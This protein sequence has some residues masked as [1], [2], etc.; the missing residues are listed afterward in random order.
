MPSHLA[1]IWKRSPNKLRQSE[2]WL[3]YFCFIGLFGAALLLFLINLGGSPLVDGN[4]AVLARVA[5]EIYQHATEIAEWLFPTLLNEPYLDR[6]PLIHV[7]VAG[8]YAIAGVNEFTTRLPGAV[9]AAISVLLLYQVGREIFIVRL[10][11]LFSALIYLTCLPV[12]RMGRLAM[13]DGPLLCFGILT[14]WAVLRSRRDLRWALVVGIGLG[15]V[16]LTHGFFCLPLGAIAI[17]FLAWDTPRLLGS[18]YLWSGISLGLAPLF[19]WYTA[20]WYHHPELHDFATTIALL[21]SR[22]TPTSWQELPSWRN[23]LLLLLQYFVPW[24]LMFYGGLKLARENLH[25]GWAKLIVVWSGIYAIAMLISLTSQSWYFLM[26]YPALALAGGAQLD[27]IYNLPSYIPYPRYWSIG[28]AIMSVFTA[29]VG[30]YCGFTSSIDFSL[31]L[32]FAFLTLTFGATAIFIA[33]R[34]RQFISLLFWG[35][36]VS[37]LLLVASSH[38]VWELD[39]LEPV[40]PIA[41]IINSNVPQQEIIYTSWSQYPSSLNFYSDRPIITEAIT[42]LKQRWQ[43]HHSVYLLVDRSTIEKLNISPKAIVKPFNDPASNWML[44]IK[45]SG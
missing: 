33:R 2:I 10:P 31:L 45:N 3:D 19:V 24:S 27:Q 4:E 11:A 18:I 23:H 8:L 35:L 30:L 28:L 20:Q 16:G 37:Y 41:E 39:N 42:Q 6:P 32:V 25:W 38:W 5:K 9:L 1:S 29:G 21:T 40:K 13:L 7:M 17:L 14:I 15:A 34:E 26:L 36:Y 44:A 12:L 43:Q 22:V